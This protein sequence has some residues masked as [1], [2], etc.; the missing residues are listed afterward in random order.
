MSSGFHGTTA[1]PTIVLQPED[2]DRRGEYN[3]YQELQRSIVFPHALN[4]LHAVCV[5]DPITSGMQRYI[6]PKW[7]N[8]TKASFNLD[9]CMQEFET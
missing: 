4:S 3:H 5:Q 8:Q 1:V 6:M 9:K 7:L 2:F